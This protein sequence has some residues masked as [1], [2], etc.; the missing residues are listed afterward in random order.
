MTTATSGTGRSQAQYC[1]V[2]AMTGEMCIRTGA[3]FLLPRGSNLTEPMARET[4]RMST[5]ASIPGA[6]QFMKAKCAEGGPASL[7]LKQLFLFFMV[8][9]GACFVVFLVMIL[10]PQGA[11]PS[12][13]GDIGASISSV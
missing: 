4:L 7:S 8:A 9:F 11:S 12:K 3:S 10:D 6:E 13:T 1:G 2:M 5:A